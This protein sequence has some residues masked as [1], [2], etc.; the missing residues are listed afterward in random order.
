MLKFQKAHDAKPHHLW[1]AMGSFFMAAVFLVWFY[2]APSEL[3][4]RW[5]W[6]VYS[7]FNIAIGKIAANRFFRTKVRMA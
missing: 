5:V 4:Y 3:P 7:G 6:I 2:I 1:I